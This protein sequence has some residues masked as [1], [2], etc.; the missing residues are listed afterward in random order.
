MIDLIYEPRN[1]NT[2]LDR[3]KCNNKNSN[4]N[5][6]KNGQKAN[7]NEYFFNFLLILLI[8]QILLIHDL[9]QKKFF[10]IK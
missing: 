6:F 7:I 2:I 1:G 9:S 10:L 3:F 5:I 8:L 4:I